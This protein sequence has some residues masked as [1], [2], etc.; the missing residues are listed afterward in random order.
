M[1]AKNDTHA[2]ERP[3]MRQIRLPEFASARSAESSSS[4]SN[5]KP[6]SC[7]LIQSA[8]SRSS[9]V[10]DG[11]SQRR[12]NVSNSRSLTDRSERTP[13]PTSRP[14]KLRIDRHAPVHQD[15]STQLAGCSIATSLWR[16]V[17]WISP[18]H[19][20]AVIGQ[21]FDLLHHEIP[22]LELVVDLGGPGLKA[23]DALVHVAGQRRVNGQRLFEDGVV[24]IPLALVPAREDVAHQDPLPRSQEGRLV[25]GLR[26]RGGRARLLRPRPLRPPSPRWP[27]PLA[28]AAARLAAAPTKSR[29]SGS[30]R[31]GRELNSGW[32]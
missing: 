14:M 7:A 12:V 17:I 3:G 13:P 30:G 8:T 25:Q 31:V 4:T 20:D 26:L 32:N 22:V 15:R 1:W 9:P 6:S 24:E 2:S 28:P 21:R 11:I 18:A 29:K 5:P 16:P 27:A 10:S 19:E 23:F